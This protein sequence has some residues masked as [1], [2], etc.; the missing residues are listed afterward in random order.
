MKKLLLTIAVTSLFLVGNAQSTYTIE[1][2]PE[3]VTNLVDKYE[4]KNIEIHGDSLK[5]HYTITTYRDTV[6]FLVNPNEDCILPKDYVKLESNF[7]AW[8]KNKFKI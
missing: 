7:I 5:V 1:S 2:S 6:V 3:S 4:L 8:I